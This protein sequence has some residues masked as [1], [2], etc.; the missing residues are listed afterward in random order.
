MNGEP[1]KALYNLEEDPGETRNVYDGFPDVVNKLTALA[2]EC[3]QDLGDSAT[4]T[5]G[6]NIRKAGR[7]NNPKKLTKYNPDH[8]YIIALYDK[9]EEG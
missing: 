6:K 9:T 8:P 2:N 3:R 5:A 1:F 7:V 4:N